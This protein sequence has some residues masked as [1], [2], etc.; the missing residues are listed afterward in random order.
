MRQNVEEYTKN[1][2]KDYMGNLIVPERACSEQEML[3][4]YQ[5]KME[6]QIKEINDSNIIRRGSKIVDSE[7]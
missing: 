4:M 2:L 1:F 3:G 7:L 5:M 6:S